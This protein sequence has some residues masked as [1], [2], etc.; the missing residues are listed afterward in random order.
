MAVVFSLSFWST[1]QAQNYRDSLEIQLVEISEKTKLPGFAVSIVNMEGVLYEAGFGYANLAQKTK[2]TPQTIE[3]IGSVS[4]TFIG[5]SIMQLVDAGKLSLDTK[6]NDILP[7][8]VIHPRFPDQPITLWQLATHTS[9]ISD[10]KQYNRKCYVPLENFV[11]GG[12][13]KDEKQ[14]FKRIKNNVERPMSAFL[15]DYL[16]PKGKLYKKQNFNKFAPGTQYE[17]T[18]IGATLA[19]LIVEIVAQQPYSEYTSTHILQPLKMEN[20]AWKQSK[21]DKAKAATIYFKDHLPMP[22]YTLITYPDGGLLSN[23]HDMSIYLMAMMKCY[24]GKSDFLKHDLA[25]EMMK[26][27]FD[28]ERE[29]SGIFWSIARN[30]RIGHAGGDPG[31]FTMLQFDP[32]TKIGYVFLTNIAGFDDPDMLIDFR[33]IWKLVA[34]HGGK[35]DD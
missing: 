22:K 32:E 25:R 19:A 1:S 31:I 4:K 21:I 17:Y 5:L 15:A 35:L 34:K 29:R 24:A 27:Q 8:K 30:G 10:G 7:F 11:A 26:P 13:R 23:C 14:Y 28:A 16:V 33:R 18:N 20:S 12:Q 3:N 2:F 9:G 6:I